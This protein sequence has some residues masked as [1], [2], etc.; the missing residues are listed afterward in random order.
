MRVFKLNVLKDSVGSTYKGRLH[1][2]TI[3][4]D[5]GT[6]FRATFT[7]ASTGE[8]SEFWARWNDEVPEKPEPQEIVQAIDKARQA[9][10][11]LI[12]LELATDSASSVKRAQRLKQ[13]LR[14]VHI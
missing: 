10:S 9:L 5:N 13:A 11:D 2:D 12:N 14:M 1:E 3:Q 6:R 4:D 7:V 8:T